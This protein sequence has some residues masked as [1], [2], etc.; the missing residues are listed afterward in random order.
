MY[1][2]I[3]LIFHFEI[4]GRQYILNWRSKWKGKQPE[5]EAVVFFFNFPWSS[6]KSCIIFRGFCWVLFFCPN[7]AVWKML[8]LQ[9]NVIE[10]SQT[11]S[12]P[13]GLWLNWP[14]NGL[15]WL[16]QGQ[17]PWASSMHRYLGLQKNGLVMWRDYC[18]WRT[19]GSINRILFMH[20]CPQQWATGRQ[21]V[22]GSGPW[23]WLPR[24]P[25]PW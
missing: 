2:T 1:L 7:N 25:C 6:I 8:S 16:T 3:N 4:N 11:T 10:G 21:A 9:R 5:K 12:C 20:L 15:Q 13:R 22:E 17:V 23:G 18:S 14:P 19:L 24:L